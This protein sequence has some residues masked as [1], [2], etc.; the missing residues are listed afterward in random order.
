LTARLSI[1]VV[2]RASR[3]ITEATHWWN[4]NRP[5]APDGIRQELERAFDLIASHPEVGAQALNARLRGVRRVHLTSIG[6]HLYYR[7]TSSAV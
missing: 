1:H 4:Q 3:E 7:V 5:A 2:H 6:Y